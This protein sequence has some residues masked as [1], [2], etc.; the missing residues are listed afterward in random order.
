MLDAPAAWLWVAA[1]LLPP[2]PPRSLPPH[3][4][5]CRATCRPPTPLDI[6]IAI[7]ITRNVRGCVDVEIHR[8]FGRPPG[9]LRR[10]RRFMWHKQV[11]NRL[12]ERTLDLTAVELESN[13]TVALRLGPVD[14]GDEV[15]LEAFVM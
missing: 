3:C 2:A 15:L 8:R 11:G 12:A 14:C 13:V 4:Q 6:A 5:A 1:V 7:A 10:L 9:A